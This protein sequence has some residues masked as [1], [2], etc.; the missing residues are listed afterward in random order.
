MRTSLILI[1]ILLALLVNHF[2][3]I[4]PIVV[5]IPTIPVNP[6]QITY[7]H[8]GHGLPAPED[9]AIDG[10]GFGYIGLGDGRIARMK[11]GTKDVMFKN[12]TR[13]GEAL[14]TCGQRDMEE[15]CGRPL[16]ML[17]VSASP[18][19][20]YFD[21]KVQVF[22]KNQ[23]LLVADAYKGLLAVD[24]VGVIVPLVNEVNGVPL[25]FSNS[26]AQSPKTGDIYMT[27][28]SDKFARNRVVTEVFEGRA[29][30]SIYVFNPTTNSTTILLENIPF[31]N[32]IAFSDDANTLYL[33]QTS[34]WK[35]VKIDL[36]TMKEST[37]A[38]LPGYPD[39]ILLT[40]FPPLNQQVLLV[41]IG[42]QTDPN[43]IT[44]YSIHI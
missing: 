44:S 40:Y 37:M 13:T 32:G 12:F 33:A 27:H 39:N 1:P 42:S 17:F 8:V 2:C 21:S 6:K 19:L 5:E 31:P 9:L 24:A 43:V 14:A 15:T 30:G 18:F 28:S 36:L 20:Q 29:R 3:V 16:G 34:R 4:D 26:L 11:I 25:I 23:I 7:E 38:S 41:G 35:V 10:D 22:P